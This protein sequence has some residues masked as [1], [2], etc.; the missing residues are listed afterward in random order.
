MKRVL[1]F[2]SLLLICGFSAV[3]HGQ[4]RK[5]S[6]I[7]SVEWLG[8]DFTA[9]K[10]VL[11]PE[12]PVVIV[13]K[14]LRKINTLVITEQAKFDIRRF[15]GI[16]EVIN[17]IDLAND[18]N[19]KIDPSKIVTTNGYSFEMDKVRE[20]IQ[21]YDVNDKSGTGMIFIA[22]SLDKVKKT[23]SYYVCFFDLKTKEIIECKKKT[24]QVSGIGFRN[25]WASSIYVIMENWKE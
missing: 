24:A 7:K 3:V 22:E 2:F 23:G 14:Y 12:N 25:Y 11:V 8:V 15:F 9:A 16:P 6:D 4:S 20:V 13:N 5:I 17:N 21:K 18:F 10:F 19:A 1:L